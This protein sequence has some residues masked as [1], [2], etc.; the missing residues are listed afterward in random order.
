[1]TALEALQLAALLFAERIHAGF[2]S[3]EQARS[4]GFEALATSS[5]AVR[6]MY[7]DKALAALEATG[8]LEE[9]ASLRTTLAAVQAERDEALQERADHDTEMRIWYADMERQRDTALLAALARAKEEARE[10]CAAI[11]D[12]AEQR[13]RDT[14]EESLANGASAG[15]LVVLNYA[16]AKRTARDIATR[17][18]AL[19][20]L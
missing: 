5:A 1:M 16:Q 8:V 15:D 2:Y 10:E 3:G 4:V 13:A 11:A 7:R 9:L 18:R 17:I 12:A 6:E 19:R 20:G 14:V